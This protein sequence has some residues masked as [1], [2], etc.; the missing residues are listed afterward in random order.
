MPNKAHTATVN[1][2]AQR[3]GVHP[4]PNGPFDVQAE[5]FSIDVETSASLDEAVAKLRLQSGPVYIAVTNK[6]GI[7]LALIKTEGTTIGVMD[8]Q[9]YI[10][11]NS[12]DQPPLAE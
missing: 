4:T 1:R 6:E 9:G 10:V 5:K 11:R 7:H 12:G 3:Y 8:P 2:I